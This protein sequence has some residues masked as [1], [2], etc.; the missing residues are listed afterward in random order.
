MSD[1]QHGHLYPMPEVHQVVT[2]RGWYDIHLE[3]P[4]G[5]Q[6]TVIYTVGFALIGRPEIIS[7]GL[8][9]PIATH[10]LTQIYHR[11]LQHQVPFAVGQVY[12]DLANLPVS[13]GP[14]SNRWQQRICTVTAEYYATYH[15]EQT[16]TAIQLLWS[17]RQGRLPID[18][19]FDPLMRRTQ[20]LLNETVSAA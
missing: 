8:P 1:Q 6:A 20:T 19:R 11:M 16:F 4:R 15:P 13:F 7:V 10:M 12:R 9:H 3:P 14:V 2:G 17:D 18:R 5:I